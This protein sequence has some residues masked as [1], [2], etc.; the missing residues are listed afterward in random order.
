MRDRRLFSAGLIGGVPAPSEDAPAAATQDPEAQPDEIVLPS[1]IEEL[2][3]LVAAAREEARADAQAALA[4]TRAEL[5]A[6][7]QQL[8]ALTEQV[9]LGRRAWAEEVRNVLGEL[10]IVGVRQVVN[11]STELQE[12]MLRDRFAEVGE[13][14]IGEQEVMIR[15]RPEDEEIARAMVGDRD[16]W[17][18]IPDPD[19]SGGIIADT[20]SG[21]IDATLGA[22]VSGLTDSVQE[23]QS[24]GVTEE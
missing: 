4:G 20:D 22:A 21:K 8:A 13:R 9:D 15:V 11:E 17:R 2:E 10:V 19:I 24:E 6:D 1:T 5:E 3:A 14:L 7:R 18:V 16:G 23:W 12:E